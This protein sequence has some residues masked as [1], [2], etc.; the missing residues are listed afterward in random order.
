MEHE[1]TVRRCDVESGVVFRLVYLAA[2]S[3]SS[4]HGVSMF[5]DGIFVRMHLELF[6]GSNVTTALFAFEWHG[7]PLGGGGQDGQ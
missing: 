2:K 3:F 5:V 7:M 1:K 6:G 4:A